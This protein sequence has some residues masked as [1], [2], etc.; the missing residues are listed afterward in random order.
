MGLAGRLNRLKPVQRTANETG[1]PLVDA[2]IGKNIKITEQYIDIR[3]A[4]KYIDVNAGEF[5]FNTEV[6]I[7]DT[8][9]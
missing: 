6:Y 3:D 8:I 7:N 4:K 5:Y 1:V 9:I 2:N